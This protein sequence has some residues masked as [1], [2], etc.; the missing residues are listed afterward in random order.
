MNLAIAILKWVI[1]AGIGVW[2]IAHVL[3]LI[4]PSEAVD[5]SRLAMPEVPGVGE[6]EAWI[7]ANEAEVPDLR[8]GSAKR[9]VWAG[10]PGE[11]T[12]VS[13]VVMHGFS[14]GVGEISPVPERVAEALGANLFLQRLSGHGRDGAA[15]AEPSA[16]DWLADMGEA[17]AVGRVLGRRVMAMGVSTG[18]ALVTFAAADPALSAEMDAAVLIS[19]NYRV[20]G[21]VGRAIEWPGAASW[22]PLLAGAER[23]L[24]PANELQAAIWTT[25]YPTRSVAPLGA[26]TRQAR[27]INLAQIEVTSLIFAAEQDRVTD[28][29]SARSAAA[30]WG[31]RSVLVPVVMGPDDDPS[32]HVLAGE[33]RS[34]GQTDAMVERILAFARSMGLDAGVQ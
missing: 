9:I 26:L 2:A 8:D 13:I 21:L 11:Q 27:R 32:A 15:M 30:R 22:L 34:P 7:A 33:A 28:A 10:A 16:G 19:P 17:M 12:A 14:S 20:K 6:I 18:G 1:F 5:E 29:A 25:Q 31:A 24:P 4:G 3:D 23:N